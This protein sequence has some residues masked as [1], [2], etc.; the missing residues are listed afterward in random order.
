VAASD[1]ASIAPA[2]GEHFEESLHTAQRPIVHTAALNSH[3]MF[4]HATS[5]QEDLRCVTACWYRMRS[6]LLMAAL[7]HWVQQLAPSSMST[8]SLAA[9][10]V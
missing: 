7:P 2:S 3:A 1:A 8:Q 10:H 4:G 9:A 6:F 5:P